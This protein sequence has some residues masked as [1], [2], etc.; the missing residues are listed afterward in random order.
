MDLSTKLTNMCLCVNCSKQLRVF[1]RVSWK[2]DLEWGR[3]VVV[4]SSKGGDSAYREA[5]EI[6][7]KRSSILMVG[8]KAD[9][10]SEETKC[11]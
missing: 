1:T 7:F 5:Q 9:R 11:Y 2:N 3:E 6:A 8:H 4:F 10:Y